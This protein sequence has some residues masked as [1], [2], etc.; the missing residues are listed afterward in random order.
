MRSFRSRP[1]TPNEEGQVLHHREVAVEAEALRH[2]ADDAADLLR[3]LDRIEAGHS[4]VAFRGHHDGR[5]QADGGRL[6]GAIGPDKA[7]NLA[8]GDAQVQ[9]FHGG[10]LP[11]ALGQVFG[12]DDGFGV[13]LWLR[14]RD[15]LTALSASH[16][17]LN[18]FYRLGHDAA[19]AGLDQGQPLI[20]P[21]IT[22]NMVA[23]MGKIV[24]PPCEKT[25]AGG[26]VY[27]PCFYKW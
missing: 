13:V 14:V 23:R 1:R 20:H 26:R 25:G 2:V 17:S 12:S 27:D 19:S 11:E 22:G 18:F 10:N 21:A 16:S 4:G 6:A 8:A 15:G 9:P 5:Q 24:K 3:F 7:E